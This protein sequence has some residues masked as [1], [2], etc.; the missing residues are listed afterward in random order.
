MVWT[1]CSALSTVV[2]GDALMNIGQ[3]LVGGGAKPGDRKRGREDSP[4]PPQPLKDRRKDPPPAKEPVINGG[5]FVTNRRGQ[6][7]C[8]GFNDGSCL[9]SNYLGMCS[10]SERFAHQCHFCLKQDHG[11]NKCTKTEA[12]AP[13]PPK[14]KGAGRG[15][16]QK[17]R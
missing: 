1:R 12:S 5:K 14:N 17:R 3:G 10:K 13:K 2:D 7:L 15:K 9:K 8:H 4:P 6:G 16:G 11:A